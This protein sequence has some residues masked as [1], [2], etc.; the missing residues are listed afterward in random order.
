MLESDLRICLGILT[1]EGEAAFDFVRDF[2]SEVEINFSFGTAEQPE[3]LP[4]AGSLAEL[5][6]GAFEFL[7]AESGVQEPPAPSGSGPRQDVERRLER[8]EG[9]FQS[10]QADLKKL[11]TRQG[12]HRQCRLLPRRRLAS[13]PLPGLFRAPLWKA[14]ARVWSRQLWIQAS[15]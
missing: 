5:A 7:T 3:L 14:W 10:I 8:L 2:T 11:V 9:C 6:R 15:T 4:H 12:S 13:G 1:P